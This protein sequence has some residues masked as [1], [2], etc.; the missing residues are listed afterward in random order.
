MII[1]WIYFCSEYD[2]L[3]LYPP[4]WSEVYKV[5]RSVNIIREEG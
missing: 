3:E 2:Q 5:E 4:L 1:I